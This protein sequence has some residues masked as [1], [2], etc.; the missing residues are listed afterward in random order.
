LAKATRRP[1]ENNS[2]TKNQILPTSGEIFPDGPVIELVSTGSANGNKPALLFW[3][4]DKAVVAPQAEYAGHVY[5]PLDLHPTIWSA[6]RLPHAAIGY[7]ATGAF[8]K[9]VANLFE[10]YIGFSTPE[11]VLVAIWNGTTW[12]S[13]RLSSPPA[14]VVSGPDISHAITFFRLLG[15]VCR[16][17]LMLAEITRSAFGSLPMALKPTVMVSQPDLPPRVWSL[18]CGSNYRGIFIPGRAGNVLDVVCSKVAFTG[19]N[20]A[21]HVCGD[22]ALHLALPPAHRDLPQL[23]DLG[24]EKIANQFQPRLLMYRLRHI[25]RVRESYSA[26]WPVTFPTLELARN[27]M[28]CVPDE[29]ELAQS[30]IPLLESQV[31]DVLASRACDPNAAIIEVIWILLHRGTSEAST[32]R[33]RELVNALLRSR[34]ESREYSAVEIGWKLRGLGIPRHRSPKSMLVQF[35]R[36]SSRRVHLLARGFGLKLAPHPETCA[37][38]AAPQIIAR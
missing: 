5:Q 9:K 24:Q 14:L 29:P 34:G 22:Q 38:C 31:Q 16:H 33:V 13:D 21:S 4:G 12:L 2:G 25:Q 35:S 26:P 6:T 18:W 8:F 32:S 17:P 20:G 23:D 30:V 1:G 15:C 36:E 27:L 11:A 10:R 3:D 28:A 19:M 7:G 37:D